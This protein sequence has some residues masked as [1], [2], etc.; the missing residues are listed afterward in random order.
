MIINV[1]FRRKCNKVRV[2]FRLGYVA[3]RII[4][5]VLAVPVFL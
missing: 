2:V 3:I 5:F 1:K 4:P